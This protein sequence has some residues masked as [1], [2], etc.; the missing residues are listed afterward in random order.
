MTITPLISEFTAIGELK[1][2]DAKSD[3]RVKYL[4]LSVDREELRIKVAKEQP[5]NLALKLE[6]GSKLKVKGMLK[7]KPKEDLS[8]YKA[9]G[10]Q[11]LSSPVVADTPASKSDKSKKS[12]KKAKVLIC[13]KSNCWKKGGRAVCNLLESELK[14][15]G[16]LEN[17][18]IK[19]TGCLKKCKQ[20]P[21]MLVLPDKEQYVRVKPKQVSS[22]V[23]KHLSQK[24]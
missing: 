1:E 22:I 12:K 14:K 6:L 17:V 9:Y 7:R 11:L 20:A 8:E 15:Q 19:K 18:E 16:S 23:E 2:V 13:Q 10:I 24:F 3:G 4:L 5:K 21:T